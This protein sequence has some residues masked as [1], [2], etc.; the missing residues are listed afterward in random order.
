MIWDIIIFD[1]LIEA[2]RAKDIDK[3]RLNLYSYIIADGIKINRL[4]IIK[5]FN[6]G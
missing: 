2:D 5:G 3:I 6:E 4:G 1:G